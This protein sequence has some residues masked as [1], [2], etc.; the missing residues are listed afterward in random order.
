MRALVGSASTLVQAGQSMRA[1]E[2]LQRAR[3]QFPST[4]EAAIAL[5]WNTIL[6]RLYIRAPSQPAYVYGTAIG[7]QN[8]K[9]RD[10]ADIGIDRE[11]NLLVAAK[12]AVTVFNGKGGV[13]RTI[14]VQEPRSLFLSAPGKVL[15]I[16]DEG[17]LFEEGKPSVVLSTTTSDGKL[18]PLKLDAGVAAS[19]GDLLVADH[20]L[21]QVLRFSPDGKPK[22]EFARVVAHRLAVSEL[23]DV[24]ALDTDAKA[25][26]LFGR[27]AKM[28]TRIPERGTG[29]QL[30]RPTDVAFDRLGHLYILDRSG[31]LVFAM[32]G[33]KLITTFPL[34]EKGTGAV[35]SPEALALDSAARLYIF[36]DRTST[37]QVFR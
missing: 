8:T 27:D 23:D 20:D 6:Y 36:D 32:Q 30:R 9:I 35:G 4:R 37:V 11:N 12:T 29:Y 3:Q 13:A 7:G 10:I 16:H 17:S 19:N 18:K 26:T 24:A 34:P 5:D 14:T 33:P 28:L 1:M 15:T 25:V 31:V 2:Q 21:K 22:G